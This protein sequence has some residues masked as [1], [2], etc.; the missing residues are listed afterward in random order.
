MKDLLNKIRAELIHE[1][2]KLEREFSS[3]IDKV[4]CDEMIDS[5]YF[6]G[7]K[8]ALEII[9]KHLEGTLSREEQVNFIFKAILKRIKEGGSVD[10]FI[11]NM[12]EEFN[13]NALEFG[14]V[15]N[16]KYNRIPTGRTFIDIKLTLKTKK[17]I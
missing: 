1:R 3:S 4:F 7:I 8:K 6:S 12:E 11:Y 9:D 15:P 13:E 16:I 14:L 2:D 5:G 10:S 17:G